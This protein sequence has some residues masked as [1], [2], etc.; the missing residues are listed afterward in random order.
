MQ[1]RYRIKDRKEHM[2]DAYLPPITASFRRPHIAASIFGY[3]QTEQSEIMTTVTFPTPDQTESPAI[4]RFTTP[5][6]LFARRI[7]PLR[8][9]VKRL[10][11]R[12]DAHIDRLWNVDTV[13]IPDAVAPGGVQHGD[14]ERYESIW[15]PVLLKYLKPLK[16]C[17]NDVVFDVGSGLGRPLMAFSRLGVKRCVGIEVDPKLAKGAEENAKRLRGGRCE[18]ET[19]SQD[20]A[21]A[22]YSGGTIYCFFNPFGHAT[23][24]NVLDRIEQTLTDEPRRIQIAYLNPFHENAMRDS[25]WLRFVGRRRSPLHT[26]VASYWVHEP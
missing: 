13:N 7:T 12:R 26:I 19:L 11:V 23:L 10:R 24:K 5:W 8:S 3:Q 6:H 20:A 25:P 2:A 17:V 15:Y 1:T 21:L 18:I 9:L 16:P 22:D 4:E 14:S